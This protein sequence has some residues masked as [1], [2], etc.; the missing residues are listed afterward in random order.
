MYSSAL[1]ASPAA[2]LF[3]WY[4]PS[5]QSPAAQMHGTDARWFLASTLILF[6]SSSATRPPTSAVAGSMPIST[7]MPATGSS[8]SAPLA[9]SLTTS[10]LTKVSPLTSTGVALV[11]V[12]IFL[13]AS[14]ASTVALSARK[15]SFWRWIS[16]TDLQ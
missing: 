5:V 9:L 8:V 14:T 7:K 12:F 6:H 15:K 16:V 11:T 3:W 10:A 1:T 4:R 2:M 13:W